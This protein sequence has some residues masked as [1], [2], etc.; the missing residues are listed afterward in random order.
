MIVEKTKH[1]FVTK[2][3]RF[4]NKQTKKACGSER[5]SEAKLLGAGPRYAAGPQYAVGLGN[6]VGPGNTVGPGNRVGPGNKAGPGNKVGPPI[7]ILPIV[8]CLLP[9]VLYRECSVPGRQKIHVSSKFGLTK[10]DKA[11]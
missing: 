5:L 10:F 9:S 11:D 7:I 2:G 3:R 6:K 8:Y 4:F 1:L